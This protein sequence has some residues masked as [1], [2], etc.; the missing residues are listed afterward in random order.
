[1]R[2]FASFL[3]ASSLLASMIGCQTE[4]PGDKPA[5][6]DPSTKVG[7]WQD[8]DGDGDGDP[9]TATEVCDLTV[10]FVANGDDCDDT[11]AGISFDAAEEC[12]GIDQDCDTLIDDGLIERTYFADTDGDGFGD[13]NTLVKACMLP[14]NASEDNTD[15]DDTHA[16]AYPAAPEICD[17]YDN[18]CNGT[19]D[20]ADPTLDPTT[21]TIYYP[22]R[23]QD[24]YGD[25]AFGEPQCSNPNPAQFTETPG[26][27]DDANDAVL[28]G[29]MEVC[30]TADND[31]DTLIDQ[32][33]PDLDPAE[34][35]TFYQDLDL[36]GV[37]NDLVLVDA[38]FVGNGYAEVGG[39][40]NDNEPL[41]QGPKVWVA[42]AD[43]DGIGAGPALGG[44]S[45]VEPG[46]NTAPDP[47]VDDCD[48]ADPLKFPGNPEICGDGLDQDCSGA[49]QSCGPLGSFVVGNG[50]SWVTNPPT[51]TCLE[52]CALLLGGVSTD[53]HCSTSKVK[54]DYQAFVSGYADATYCKTPVAEDFKKNSTYNCGAFG[55]S[56][57]AYVQDNCFSGETN[58]CWPN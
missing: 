42:D 25:D 41:I 51:Y 58:Y 1:M 40:C 6:C 26:D 14:A 46:P 34:L 17:G 13:P 32:D 38:C 44:A 29:G 3:L 57:S 2:H 8:A 30:D 21:T 54:L 31:C 43:N 5:D 53:Y 7:A 16:D 23:D 9:A 19:F 56:Y 47:A 15:C 12:D 55:C 28:P 50:P 4:D 48:D 36:D 39:D 37:G 49:D 18:N 10:G 52:A 45:C 11:N 35:S 20:D 33:D 22:D 27:C 24:G